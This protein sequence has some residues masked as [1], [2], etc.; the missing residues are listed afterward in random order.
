[1]IPVATPDSPVTLD[2]S[3]TGFTAGYQNVTIVER[4]EINN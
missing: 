1:M 3:L 2:V 4:D